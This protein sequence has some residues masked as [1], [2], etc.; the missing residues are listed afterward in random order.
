LLGLTRIPWGT[1]WLGILTLILAAAWII[2]RLS[3]ISLARL[4]NSREVAMS[5]HWGS[6]FF[7]FVLI[8]SIVIIGL[9]EGDRSLALICAVFSLDVGTTWLWG[10]QNNYLLFS[11]PSTNSWRA[12]LAPPIGGLSHFTHLLAQA[13]VLLPAEILGLRKSSPPAGGDSPQIARGTDGS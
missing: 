5:L 12:E 9:V 7:V 8:W 3:G 13:Y 10:V 6:G 2:W 1:P 11:N 4:T